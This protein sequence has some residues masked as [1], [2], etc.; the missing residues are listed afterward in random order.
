MKLYYSPDACSLAPHIIAHAAGLDIEIER[1]DMRTKQ[2]ASGRDFL[3][4]NPKGYVP[5][6]ELEDG[7]VLTEGP[8]ISQYLADLAP[9]RGLTP[10]AGTRQ[11]YRTME[12]LGFINSELH[13]S[14]TP[15]F[16]SETPPA[17]RSDRLAHLQRRYAF[18]EA[19][20]A[21][22]PY[23]VGDRFGVADAYLFVVT[24]WATHV[25][26]DLSAFPNLIAFQRR[27][28][29]RPEVLAA[30]AAERAA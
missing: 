5:A 11:R 3:A 18:V 6:L 21:E 17:Q 14:Y 4:V 15:L 12:M 29:E 2:T 9:D 20:L 27:V 24:S 7:S 26:L 22:H 10:A 1:V 16:H 28:A 8:V 30:R 19:Q 25:G 23:L 13:K